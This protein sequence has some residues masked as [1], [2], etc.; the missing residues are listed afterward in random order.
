MYFGVDVKCVWAIC[1]NSSMKK[2]EFNESKKY[3]LF[4]YND[5]YDEYVGDIW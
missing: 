2:K 1:W 3:A 4:D 5:V